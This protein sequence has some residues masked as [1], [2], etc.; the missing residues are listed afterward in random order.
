M[1]L[2]CWRCF[3]A[4]LRPGLESDPA[5]AMRL[6]TH[7]QKEAAKHLNLEVSLEA[8]R[9]KPSLMEAWRPEVQR[10]EVEPE[11]SWASGFLP[12][13]P[14]NLLRARQA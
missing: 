14:P 12:I 1:C 6:A 13:D 7:G 3:Q 2:F 11:R 4:V 10:L 5:V 9:I 8:W